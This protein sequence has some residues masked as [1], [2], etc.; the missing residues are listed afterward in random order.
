MSFQMAEDVDSH[1]LF[2]RQ[3]RDVRLLAK[4]L[5][6]SPA[7]QRLFR[8]IGTVMEK[9][10]L[11][12]HCVHNISEAFEE[13]V[14]ERY[15]FVALPDPSLQTWTTMKGREV[16]SGMPPLPAN[17]LRRLTHQQRKQLEFAFFHDE[18]LLRVG[19]R[20]HGD[21]DATTAAAYIEDMER[22]EEEEFGASNLPG[23][24]GARDYFFYSV[25]AQQQKTTGAAAGAASTQPMVKTTDLKK[26][27]TVWECVFQEM[28]KTVDKRNGTKRPDEQANL[29]A[30]Y[31]VL[32]V[33]G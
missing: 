11:K 4:L 16:N 5:N 12:N 13:F 33:N 30:D 22:E 9:S 28:R 15:E 17:K 18:D 32:E 25:D 29:A 20:L 27:D 23:Q 3:L 14:E 8:C 26:S 19:Q 6:Y 31:A 7:R 1:P 10:E 21:E 24:S 2:C